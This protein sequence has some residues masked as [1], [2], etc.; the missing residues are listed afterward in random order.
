MRDFFILAHIKKWVYRNFGQSI[1]VQMHAGCP[2][3]TPPVSFTP[4]L[5][6]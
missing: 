3:T 5:D 1:L 6:S 4:K 2:T